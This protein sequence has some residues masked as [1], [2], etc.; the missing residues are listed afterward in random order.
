MVMWAIHDDQ[1]MFYMEVLLEFLLLITPLPMW[2]IYS[3]REVTVSA[4]LLLGMV[5]VGSGS[6]VIQGHPNEKISPLSAG[7]SI[8]MGAQAT[9]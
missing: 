2:N 3:F 9:S 5:G 8:L 1:V 6:F 4:K 7:K